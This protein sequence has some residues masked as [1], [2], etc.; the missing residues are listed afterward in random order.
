MPFL[1]GFQFTRAVNYTVVL[2]VNV[3]AFTH[4]L[5]YVKEVGVFATFAIYVTLLFLNRQTQTR[6]AELGGIKNKLTE[7]HNTD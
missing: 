6:A 2:S 4:D 5:W 7:K 3:I 1:C